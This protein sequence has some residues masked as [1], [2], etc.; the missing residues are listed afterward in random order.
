VNFTSGTLNFTATSAMR[1][2]SAADVT[3]P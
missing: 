2:N 1:R 3:P